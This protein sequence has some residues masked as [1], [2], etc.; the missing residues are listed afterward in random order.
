MGAVPK[1]EARI[2][3]REHRS[4]NM[5]FADGT[6]E[7]RVLTMNAHEKFQPMTMASAAPGSDLPGAQ[8]Q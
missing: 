4:H 1:P 3:P 2:P 6:S 7:Y 5:R 8:R